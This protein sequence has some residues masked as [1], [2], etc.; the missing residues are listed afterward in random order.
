MTRSPVDFPEIWTSGASPPLPF[1]FAIP[2]NA[3]IEAGM[4]L[5]PE[6][7]NWIPAFAGM[8]E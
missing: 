1:H 2:A 4:A 6:C 8:T 3:G 7:R 5:P